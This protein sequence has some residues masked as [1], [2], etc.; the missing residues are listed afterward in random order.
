MKTISVDN[1]VHERITNKQKKL[2]EEQKVTIQ[3]KDI[4]RKLVEENI[5]KLEI[6]TK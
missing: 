3:L 4:M 2:L 5:D 6:G 1:D